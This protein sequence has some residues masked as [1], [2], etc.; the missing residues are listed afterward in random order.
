MKLHIGITIILALLATTLC[1]QTAAPTSKQTGPLFRTMGLGV[2]PEGLYYL[3]D[4]K[5]VPVSVTQNARS[6]FYP[7]PSSNPL[8]FYRKEKAPDGTE[9]RIPVARAT[10]PEGAKILLF[11]FSEG[12]SKTTV[13]ETL[14]DSLVAFPGGTYRVLNRLNQPLDAVIKGQKSPI[15]AH[16]AALIDVRGPGTTRFVQISFAGTTPPRTILSNNWSYNADLRTLVIAAPSV[17]PSDTPLV[18][19]IS[20][21]VYLAQPQASPAPA[22]AP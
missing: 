13:V 6:D 1:A 18:A 9:V 3:N 5:D 19:R 12:P 21:P 11:I 20:E 10:V 22:Q 15:P 14:D 17:P 2:N 8:E 16:G 4:K 7:L